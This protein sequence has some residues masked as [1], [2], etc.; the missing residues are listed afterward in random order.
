M[1]LYRGESQLLLLLLLI[2]LLYCAAFNAPCVS[3]NDE[4]SQARLSSR[5]YFEQFHK[6]VV[7]GF[8]KVYT[9]LVINALCCS[10]V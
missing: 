8:A 6:K 10:C 5:H 1:N 2:L 4:E 7:S 3:H 9:I